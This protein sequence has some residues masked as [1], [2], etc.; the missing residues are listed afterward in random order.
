[1]AAG[2]ATADQEQAHE[3]ATHEA[4]YAPPEHPA[5]IRTALDCVH[6]G[7]V[8]IAHCYQTFAA[9]DTVLAECVRRV[10]ELVAT[11]AALARMAS[12]DAPHLAELAAVTAKVCRR[13]E[14]ECRRHPKHQPC[15]DCG[16]DCAA[17]A[18][19]CDR[20]RS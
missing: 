16:E 1:M 18:R 13:C 10:Q 7:D 8:C 14:E 3:H 6:S 12:L 9:G 17:C 20:L 5:L 15:L 4:K 2:A 19:E 11:C